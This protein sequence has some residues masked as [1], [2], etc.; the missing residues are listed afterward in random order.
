VNNRVRADAI[1]DGDVLA[2]VE[3]LRR[4]VRARVSDPDA[5]EDV[6]QETLARLLETR[7]RLDRP[8]VLPYGIAVARN[9]IASLDRERDR[10]RKHAH[11][12]HEPVAS[13]A[14][15]EVVLLREEQAAIGAAVTALPAD[16]RWLLTEYEVSGRD[17]ASLAT[18]DGASSGAVS[19]RLARARA[20]LRVHYLLAL[21]NVDL[22]TPHCRSVLLALSS[23]DQR[24]QRGVGA[25]SHLLTC[26]TCAALS[27]PLVERRRQ[28][29]AFVPW[30]GLGAALEPLRGWIARHP[31]Q[32][33]LTAAGTSAAVATAVVASGALS[34][35]V[36]VGQR[37]AESSVA[38]SAA[39]AT[40]ASTPDSAGTPT[41]ER[42]GALVLPD[43]NTVALNDTAL[44]QHLGA[45]LATRNTPVESVPADEGFWL[46]D[47]PTR[48]VWVQLMNS[49]EQDHRIRPGDRVS[50]DGEVVSH[51]PGF[52]EQVGVTTA[53]GAAQLERQGAHISVRSWVLEE[54]G[55]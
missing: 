11:R 46:G 18:E 12:L 48:R 45:Q 23:G 7:H 52:A 1:T 5:A 53:E 39:S 50:F 27:P 44:G 6:V 13:A 15:D 4:V 37:H 8:A 40:A 17:T 41:G 38:S 42:S 36:A 49:A 43:G 28:L 22:P 14:P 9:L 35:S 30:L 21:R 3:P 47:S 19:A 31:V 54:K 51:S 10:H 34:S 32:A 16:E 2:T 25:S 20:R 24:R 33:S 26:R 29:A 55:S